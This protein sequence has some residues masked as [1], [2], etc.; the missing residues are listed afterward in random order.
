MVTEPLK[1]LI[2]IHGH[3]PDGWTE[4]VRPALAPNPS[5][6]IR[7]LVVD[8][9]PPAGFT[10]LLPAARRRYAG[11]VRM[12]REI[13]ADAR[14]RSLDELVP[15]LPA[16]PEILHTACA[17]GNAGR[18][19]AEH[20]TA[21]PAHIVVVGR[22]ARPGLSRGLLP[23]VHERVVRDAPCAIIVAPAAPSR[24]LTL[25]RGVDRVATGVAP[26]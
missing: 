18:T 24:P 20:A 1:I 6:L 9:P 10:S 23:R 19:I 26:R 25:R 8:E 22:D 12:W 2:A 13:A 15:R 5:A 21:W 4:E 17:R 7:V 11:A 16:R 3:E 14:R